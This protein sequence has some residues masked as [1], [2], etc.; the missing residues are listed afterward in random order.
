MRRTVSE[1]GARRRGLAVALALALGLCL[2]G[3][4]W[5]LPGIRSWSNDDGTPELPL[6]IEQVYRDGW[7]KYPYLQPLIDRLLYA[8]FLAKWRSD[9]RLK[10]DCALPDPA[11]FADPP[12][13]M[14]RLM[15]ISRLR[16]V[17]A[18]LA[19]VLLAH[20]LAW[21]LY[22]DAG[23]ALATACL[24]ATTQ[25][26]IFYGHLGN[27]D[28]PLTA[29]FMLSMLAWLRILD[30]AGWTTHAGFGIAAACALATKESIVGA[31]VLPG[32]AILGLHARRLARGEKG[33]DGLRALLALALPLL[34]LYALVNNLAF[35]PDGYVE[36][37]RHWSSGGGIDDFDDRYQGP[38]WLAGQSL[39]RLGEAMGVPLASLALAGLCLGLRPGA[40]ALDRRASRILLLPLVG[41]QLFTIQTVHFVY[42]RF[43]LP[44]AL[45]L[46][47]PAGRLA[48]RL[49]RS[50]G[51]WHPIARSLTL[52]CIAYSGLYCL[53]VDLAMRADT[54]YAAEAWLRQALQPGSRLGLV[55][56][57]H[58]LPRTWHL[59]PIESERL[60]WEDSEAWDLEAWQPDWLILSSKSFVDLV[61]AEADARDRLLT[62]EAGY[63]VVWDQQQPAPLS[64]LPGAFVESRVSPRIV[65]LR[66]D[67]D[68]LR[69]APDA[70][71]PAGRGP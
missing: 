10:A 27:V 35:N 44:L 6:H 71:T 54:R 22:R 37:I 9:G 18:A 31:Y 61:G 30:G 59:G 36:R 38:V 28:L 12:A 3:I 57:E 42:T 66:R 5:G 2:F 8:P 24:A 68:G 62:G 58:Y 50:P 15:A 26:L 32:L 14:G 34:I 47:P 63:A 33:S 1:V 48:A 52:A 70:P 51:P 7:H 11:C 49:W 60:L 69:A 39:A 16:S 4:D 29:W 17:A 21:Q 45:L 46:L 67:P 20:A 23:A 19:L 53:N 65:I 41:Y 13:Q 56:S 55:G 25:V 40:S 64:W 43:T